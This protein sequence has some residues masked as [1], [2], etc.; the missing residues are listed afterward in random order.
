MTPTNKK[1]QTPTPPLNPLNVAS[2]CNQS[3]SQNLLSYYLLYAHNTKL[4]RILRDDALK[5]TFD[6]YI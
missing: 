2:S 1:N 3:P 5:I 6:I 4:V